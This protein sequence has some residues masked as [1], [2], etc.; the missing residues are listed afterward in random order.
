MA[1]NSAKSS[2]SSRT[3]LVTLAITFHNLGRYLPET[4]RSLAR[5][6]YPH[7]EVLVLDDGSTDLD[8]QQVFQEQEQLYPRFRFLRQQNTG[9]C[10]ARNKLLEEAG[11]VYF[12]PV[13]ADD[14]AAPDLAERLVTALE[15]CPDLSAAAVY[16][17]GFR[18][19]AESG[20]R[21]WVWAYRP[22]GGPLLIGGQTNCWGASS[23]IYRTE[24]LRAIGGYRDHRDC[25]IE[26]WHLH[27]KLASAGH[28]IGVVPRPLIFYRERPESMYR[29]VDHYTG[30]R[31]VMNDALLGSALAESQLRDLWGTLALSG[32]RGD[33]LWGQAKSEK[34]HSEI[35]LEQLKE[36]HQ[37]MASLQ[38]QLTQLGRVNADLQEHCQ[39]LEQGNNTLRNLEQSN[40]TQN[41]IAQRNNS[42]GN[43]AQS[44]SAHSHHARFSPKQT[45]ILFLHV[46][47]AGG[48][49]LLH[50]LVN[51]FPADAILDQASIESRQRDDLGRYQFVAGHVSASIIAKFDRAPLL[52]TCIRD[53]IERTL[54]EFAYCRSHGPEEFAALPSY[55][56]S[57]DEIAGFR[58]T[59]EKM[60]AGDLRS[61]INREPALAQGWFGNVMTE[62]TGW[63]ATLSPVEPD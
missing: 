36:A 7:C 22:T 51:Q 52:I 17:L 59:C 62:T 2:A 45:P 12:L 42:R 61:F 38:D 44:N 63:V 50:F 53:P 48:T 10:G 56:W 49:S 24:V 11:G 27:A 34:R 41:N 31:F 23:T 3:P 33:R 4:L 43:L 57:P 39:L 18:D 60:K 8:S 35:L 14:V 32:Q 40:S 5:Q 37:Q 58:E 16:Y 25:N 20:E 46:R 19:T 15:R 21:D 54:S 26:D 47:K 29:T 28:K 13:D 1:R 55:D 6:T 30:H 9:L